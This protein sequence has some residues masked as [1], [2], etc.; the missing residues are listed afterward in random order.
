LAPSDLG[1]NVD[2]PVAAARD[3]NARLFI[4]NVLYVV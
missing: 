1:H 4:K 3:K 2:K